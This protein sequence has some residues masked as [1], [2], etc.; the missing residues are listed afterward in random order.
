[1]KRSSILKLS[2]E[3]KFKLAVHTALLASLASA[4]A[5][6]QQ[7]ATT[8]AKDDATELETLE[9]TGSRLGRADIEGALGLATLGTGIDAPG[10]DEGAV[11][12]KYRID[13]E[14]EKS[15]R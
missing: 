2:S 5:S 4:S 1:M 10:V 3:A 6:A 8:A 9:V 14:P 15:A 7:A 13:R 11:A 12:R